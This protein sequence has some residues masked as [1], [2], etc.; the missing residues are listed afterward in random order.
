VLGASPYAGISYW[1][2]TTGE[3]L[4]PRA[5]LKGDETVDVAILGGGYSGLWTAY[6]LLRAEPSLSVAVLESQTCGFGA[7]GRNGSWC[8]PRF[9]VG[10]DVIAKRHGADA[11]RAL[12]RAMQATVAEVGRVCEAE[13]IDAEFRIRGILSLARGAAQLPT[14]KAS[15]AMYEKLGLGDLNQFLDADA[16][17][18][19]VAVADIQG[20]MYTPYSA[21]LHPAK[22]VR[23]IARAVERL[24]GKIYEQTAV[25]SI[26]RGANAALVTEHGRVRARRAVIVAGEGYLPKVKGFERAIVPMSSSIVLTEPLTDSQWRAIGWNGGEGIGSQAYTIDYLTKT[27]DGRILYGSRGARYLYGSA[28]EGDGP[29]VQEVHAMMRK[30]LGEWFPVLESVRFTHGWSGFLGVTRDWTPTVTFDSDEKLGRIYGYT[31]RGVGTSNMCARLL[32]SLVLDRPSDLRALPISQRRSPNWEP[33]PLRWMG[34]R[35]IQDA[36]KRMDE[37]RDSGRSPPLDAPAATR[38]SAP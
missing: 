28:T 30:R 12:V 14:V 7:S 29:D 34:I 20:A 4:T 15:V 1:L 17:R 33:E 5:P 13:S 22:L 25:R 3:A 11:A 37:A 35:Y 26:D 23:G 6:Y 16:A 27:V 32:T 21:Y 9:P 31:G 18:A 24:G 2:E 38:L 19:R 10:P 36:F 8:S